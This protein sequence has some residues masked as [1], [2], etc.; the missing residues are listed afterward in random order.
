MEL[1]LFVAVSLGAAGLT[2]IGSLFKMHQLLK[3]NRAVKEELQR[4]REINRE[5]T[6]EYG[7][8]FREKERLRITKDERLLETL[9]LRDRLKQSRNQVENLQRQ[10][11]WEKDKVSLWMWISSNS[12]E[13]QKH[14]MVTF[15]IGF[16]FI[17]FGAASLALMCCQ[18]KRRAKTERLVE[19]NRV[20][21]ALVA[22]YRNEYKQ[23]Y[24]QHR[25]VF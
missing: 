21:L 1:A 3:N 14:D 16:C 11:L 13:T 24:V 10:Q 20:L 8:I 9:A 4:V 7:D 12:E 5:L 2:V 18:E 19:Q 23:L 22:Q 15:V 17:S 6:R 25:R